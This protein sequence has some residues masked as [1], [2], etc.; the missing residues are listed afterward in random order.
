M[1]TTIATMLWRL[2]LQSEWPIIIIYDCHHIRYLLSDQD[3][4]KHYYT[5]KGHK[6]SYCLGYPAT[7]IATSYCL[8]YP[9][10]ATATS[11]CHSYK[12]LPGLPRYCYTPSYCPG[13]VAVMRLNLMRPIRKPSAISGITRAPCT[14]KRVE[15]GVGRTLHAWLGCGE[16]CGEG[17][18]LHAWLLGKVKVPAKAEGRHT[19][20]HV[21]QV[22]GEVYEDTRH[23]TCA[24]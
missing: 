22:R 20:I 6:Q 4:M 1:E 16:P 7:A 19:R 18:A 11:Y 9:A 10:T 12:L 3:Q 2:T 5:M 24:R 14:A 17:H 8:G 21:C 23:Y 15:V 13:L